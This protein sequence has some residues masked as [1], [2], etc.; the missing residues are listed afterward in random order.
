MLII[1]N[2]WTLVVILVVKWT[3]HHQYQLRLN[4]TNKQSV[5]KV[6]NSGQWQH[7][8]FQKKSDFSRLIRNGNNKPQTQSSTSNGRCSKERRLI[9]CT[10]NS[11]MI[12]SVDDLEAMITQNQNENTLPASCACSAKQLYTLNRLAVI[13]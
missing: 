5:L 8:V 9:R 4:R 2:S 13:K 1:W 11:S 12:K 6:N 7:S 3:I 10:R